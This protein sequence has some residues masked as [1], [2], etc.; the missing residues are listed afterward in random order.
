MVRIFLIII[1][2]F[3]LFGKAHSQAVVE[4]L[5]FK[6]KIFSTSYPGDPMRKVQ[7]KVMS[8]VYDYLHK[9]HDIDALPN[10]NIIQIENLHS[11]ELSYDNLEGTLTY[12]DG[13]EG[14]ESSTKAGIRIFSNYNLDTTFYLLE[15][16]I[17]NRYDLYRKTITK[18][19]NKKCGTSNITTTEMELVFKQDLSQ[20]KK[21]TI[22]RYDRKIKRL[23][24]KL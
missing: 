3:V 23:L 8:L 16:G 4:H 12:T 2:S 19:S 6:H 24:R 15:Y 10:I 1:F 7:L 11:P 20:R 9:F 22:K 13:I 5:V 18:I 17:A 14:I 21:L